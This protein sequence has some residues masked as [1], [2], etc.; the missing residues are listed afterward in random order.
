MRTRL[1]V[2]IL[3][4]VTC[5]ALSAREYRSREVTRN[6]NVSI[7]AHR[8]GKRTGPAPATGKITSS[9]SP[10]AAPTPFRTLQWQIIAE[11]RA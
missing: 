11:A 7:P 9:R 2:A 4:T 3:L 8:L 5:T 1:I 6:S 10:V